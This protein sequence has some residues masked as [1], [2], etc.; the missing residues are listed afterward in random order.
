[1]SDEI[2][3]NVNEDSNDILVQV[4]EF[5]QVLSVNGETGNVIVDKNTI[6]LSNVENVSIVATSGHL[7]NQI[8]KENSIQESQFGLKNYYLTGSNDNYILYLNCYG[9]TGNIYLEQQTKTAIGSK[10]VF[11][12]IGLARTTL[13]IYAS[14]LSAP[15]PP[16]T[17]VPKILYSTVQEG[18]KNRQLEFTLLNNTISFQPVD[19][20]LFTERTPSTS[21]PLDDRYVWTQ[22]GTQ[23]IIG[24][25]MFSERPLVNGTGFVLSNE[26]DLVSSS[27][28]YKTG[29]QT[30]SGVKTFVN[31]T[32]VDSVDFIRNFRATGTPYNFTSNQ[33][34]NFG[35]TGFLFTGWNLAPINPSD[36]SRSIKLS[37]GSYTVVTINQPAGGGSNVTWEAIPNKNDLSNRISFNL[38]SGNTPFKAASVNVGPETISVSGFLPREYDRFII[39]YVGG[40]GLLPSV[41]VSG[42][43]GVNNEIRLEARD[44]RLFLGSSG[45]LFQ[46]ETSALS[47][48]NYITVPV[49][50]NPMTNGTNLLAAYAKAKT[51]LPNGSALSATNRLAIILPPAIYDLGTQSLTLDTQYIDIIGSTP[52]RSKHHIKSDIGITNRGTIQQTANNVKLY[53]LTIENVDNTYIKNYA[54]SDPAA[55]FPSSNLNNTY[56]ENINLIGSVNIWSMRLSIEYSGTFKNCT[57]GDFAFGATGSAS[58]TFEDCTGGDYAFGGDGGTASGIFKNCTGGDYAFGGDGGTANGIFKNCIGTYAAFGGDLGTASGTFK[59]C[60]GGNYAFGYTASGTFENCTGGYSAFGGYGTASGTFKD[61]TGGDYAFGGGLGTASGTF[62]DCTGGDYAFGGGLGT[63]S[64]TFENCIG[65]YA[66]FGGDLGTASGTFKDC[67]GTY[68]AFGG[69]IG[70]ASGTFENCTGGDYAFGGDSGTASGIFKNCTGGDGA[71][72]GY[73]TASGT[74][75][76]CTGGDYAFGGYGTAS[77][78]FENCTGGD[79]AFGGD[80]GTASGTFK[81]CTGGDGAF[82]YDA[83]GTFENCTSG[84]YAFG[85]TAS[86]TFKDC[87][88]GDGVFGSN[89]TASGT[90]KDCTGG[91]G[92]FGGDGGTANGIFKNC[93]GGDYAFGGYGGTASGTFKDCIGGNGSF[94]L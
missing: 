79:Y 4:A 64:G 54:A 29:D 36:D 18:S 57:S 31:T 17:I 52:D 72:G 70:T 82:G 51:T 93:T 86:G 6:G 62:K 1:M 23:S 80:I 9:G 35:P 28:V 81:D 44:N 37:N 49:T 27:A 32:H 55:Y 61:C 20:Y 24:L 68:A 30:I 58:G 42:N 69:G 3:I 63:A 26:L 67:I 91:D 5:D 22:T 34:F 78:T 13:N 33:F 88:G 46:N 25:K 19:E 73:G 85:Y 45:V 56:L 83:S 66:A 47:T 48:A 53:N 16:L 90:F 94:N 76:N 59:D 21:L 75:E 12:F 60:T 41:N 87:T 77:G 71:F 74:F 84:N 38:Y 39:R 92:A 40:G 11:Q 65:T 10:Y 15:T 2:Y 7:Q 50:D 43:F 14:G 89:G 8:P